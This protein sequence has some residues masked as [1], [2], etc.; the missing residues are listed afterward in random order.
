MSSINEETW[1]EESLRAWNEWK[2]ICWVA[3][4]SDQYQ[5]ILQ[6]EI[7]NAFDKKIKKMGLYNEV[8]EIM[9]SDLDWGCEFDNGIIEQEN[10]PNSKIKN[11]K[12]YI[13]KKVE[14]SKDPE[15]KVI[16]GKL[17][18]EYGIINDIAER[19]LRNDYPMLYEKAKKGIMFIDDEEDPSSSEKSQSWYND[20][21]SDINSE[22]ILDGAGK[23]FDEK[24]INTYINNF[25]TIQDIAIAYVQLHGI[26]LYSETLL[27]FIGL[28]KTACSTRWNNIR[29]KMKN[30][31]HFL[32]DATR[33]ISYLFVS[34]LKKRLEAEKGGASLLLWVEAEI[35][36]R[37]SRKNK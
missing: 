29:T 30:N 6:K 22:E 12:D 11:Q 4:C 34:C 5:E 8:D 2:R 32:E 3:G 26:P 13:W 35:A 25:F 9:K 20:L 7:F 19:F 23:D 31:F 21:P 16:R 15:L 28:K 33:Q 27:K 37:H 10:R 1:N 18:G 24:E 14:E 17:L 36:E